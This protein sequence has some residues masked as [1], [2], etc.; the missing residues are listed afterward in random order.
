LSISPRRPRV[1][2]PGPA[3]EPIHP[4][5]PPGRPTR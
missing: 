4:R 1:D 2:Q 5:S 3:A